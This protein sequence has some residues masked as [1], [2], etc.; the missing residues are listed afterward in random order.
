[1]I[2]KERLFL[3]ARAGCHGR[4]PDACV[5]ATPDSSRF[6]YAQMQNSAAQRRL[7]RRRRW[8]IDAGDQL[9]A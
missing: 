1:R 8:L 9:H 5:E 4:Y 6:Q 7:V 3:K 2:T